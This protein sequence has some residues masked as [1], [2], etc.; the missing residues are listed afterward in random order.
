[1]PLSGSPFLAPAQALALVGQL[2]GA[3]VLV[4]HAGQRGGHRTRVDPLPATEPAG[5]PAARAGRVSLLVRSGGSPLLQPGRQLLGPPLSPRAGLLR[6]GTAHE[7]EPGL[8]AARIRAAHVS[9]ARDRWRASSP[10]W[11][12]SGSL[13][14]CGGGSGWGV[15]SDHDIVTAFYPPPQPS[16]AAGEG[17]NLPAAPTPPPHP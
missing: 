10:A 7:L 2:R 11:E 3:T 6:A 16:P 9:D 5:P 12:G 14:P 8:G 4:D 13:P 17:E 15:T 1:L